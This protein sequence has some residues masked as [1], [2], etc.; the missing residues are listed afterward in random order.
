MNLIDHAKLTSYFSCLNDQ[1]QQPNQQ[2]NL[3]LN[4]LEHEIF[5]MFTNLLSSSEVEQNDR[6]YL[7]KCVDTIIIVAIRQ[8]NVQC[9]SKWFSV[10]L[11]SYYQFHSDCNVMT[12][13]HILMNISLTFNGTVQLDNINETQVQIIRYVWYSILIKYQDHLQQHLHQESNNTCFPFQEYIYLL[14]YVN[15]LAFMIDFNHMEWIYIVAQLKKWIES[16]CYTV[17]DQYH[18]DSKQTQQFGMINHIMHYYS[19]FEQHKSLKLQ[20]LSY[21]INAD[22]VQFVL[23]WY[24]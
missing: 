15:K 19:R 4:Q 24:L 11:D 17:C 2:Q 6:W 22:I 1:Q 14:S 5:T 7:M 13:L 12:S 18:I 21:Y 20:F 16:L 10:W 3:V 9:I 23:Q 8:L